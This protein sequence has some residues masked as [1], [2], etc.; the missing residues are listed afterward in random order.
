MINRISLENFALFHDGKVGKRHRSGAES[1]AR[2]QR[3]YSDGKEIEL[4]RMKK[5]L[6]Q[7]LPDGTKSRRWNKSLVQNCRVVNLDEWNENF[8]KWPAARSA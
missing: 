2:I 4:S 6:V 1:T 3:R 8:P 5:S 7:E